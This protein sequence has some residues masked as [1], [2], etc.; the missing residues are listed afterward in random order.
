M[1][2]KKSYGRDRSGKLTIVSRYYGGYG[3]D[4]WQRVGKE[5]DLFVT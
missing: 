4:G 2:K 1:N 5:A 3:R